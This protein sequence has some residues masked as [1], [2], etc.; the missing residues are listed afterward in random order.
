MCK[1]LPIPIKSL[2]SCSNYHHHCCCHHHDNIHFPSLLTCSSV[3]DHSNIIAMTTV[4]YSALK[5]VCQVCLS[6][7][8]GYVAIVDSPSA[9]T[10]VGWSMGRYCWAVTELSAY[11][12]SIMD[13]PVVTTHCAP[14]TIEVDL[15][16]TFICSGTSCQPNTIPWSIST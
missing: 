10:K 14:D 16:S 11:Y 3:T 6:A 1:L 15:N 4:T 2:P 5:A 7:F 9:C 12:D 8:T 13:V